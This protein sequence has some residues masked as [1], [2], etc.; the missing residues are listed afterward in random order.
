MKINLLYVIPGPIEGAPGPDMYFPGAQRFIETY[1]KFPPGAEHDLVLINSNSGMTDQHRVL[2]E[3]TP[4]RII[5]VEQ[6][7]WDS[8]AQQAA[9]LQ[10]QDDDW[11]FFMSSWAHFV[12]PDWLPKI[13]AAIEEHGDC[14]YGTQ[15]SGENHLHLRGTGYC[16][17]AGAF[18]EYPHLVTSRAASFRWESGDAS[19]D[20]LSFTNFHLKRNGSWLVTPTGCHA[21]GNWLLIPNGFRSGDQSNILVHDKHTKIYAKST[22]D[23]KQT[24]HERS[25]P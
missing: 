8:G 11:C 13:V 10:M 3:A 14:L 15:A 24:L 6:T 12:M 21:H 4:H 22:D 5:D 16:C 9:A 7:G 23:E 25:Y 17:R 1:R 18:K 19:F 20:N 2:F